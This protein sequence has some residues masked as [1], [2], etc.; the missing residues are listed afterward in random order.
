MCVGFTRGRVV[1]VLDAAGRY[2]RLRCRGPVGIEHGNRQRTTTQK[3]DG[4]R[5]VQ[6][7][8][9]RD[10]PLPLQGGGRVFGPYRLISGRDDGREA[11]HTLRIG[12][13]G[14][15]GAAKRNC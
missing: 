9:N 10:V 7:G 1:G 14:H 12:G 13:H 2:R 4:E 5:H 3:F 11:E 8:W 15:V 6:S